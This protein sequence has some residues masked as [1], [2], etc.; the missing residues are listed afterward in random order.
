MWENPDATELEIDHVGTLND[1][2]P[3]RTTPL[4]RRTPIFRF[5]LQ[6]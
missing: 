5:F 4:S 2:N 1:R 6:K 3:S